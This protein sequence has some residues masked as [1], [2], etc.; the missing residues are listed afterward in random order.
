MNLLKY[1]PPPLKWY[2][3]V[4]PGFVWELYYRLKFNLYTVHT[5]DFKVWAS[6]HEQLNNIVEKHLK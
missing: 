1:T 6:M 4:I 5:I 2:E 3:K